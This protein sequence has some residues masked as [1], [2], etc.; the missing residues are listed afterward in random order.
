MSRLRRAARSTAVVQIFSLIGA[1]L[2]LVTVPLYLKW[3]GNE[4]YGLMLTA[5][6]CAGYLMFSDAGLSWASMLLISQ[7]HGRDNRQE[8]AR[9]VRNSISLAA[10]SSLLASGVIFVLLFL[11]QRAESVRLF[12]H[13]S[14]E[15]A[16]LVLAVGFQVV[17]SLMLSPVFNIFIGL[18]E[19]H[20]AAIYQGLGRIIGVGASLLA[21]ALGASLGIIM[22]SA[23][24]CVLAAGAACAVH[25][26]KRHRWA[27]RWG[28]FWEREQIRSQYRAGAKSF[29]LQIG[30]VLVGSAPV[31][32]ISSQ[33]GA[34]FVPGFTVPLTLLNTPLAIVMSFNATLQ[35]GYGEAIG[36]QDFPWIRSTVQSILRNMLLFQGLLVAGFLVLAPAFIKLWTHGR[37]EV[38]LPVLMSVLLVGLTG[39]ILSVF[40]FALSGMNR[41]KAAGLSEVINGLLCLGLG[42]LVV[43][44]AGYEWIGLGIFAAAAATSVWILPGQLRK[45]LDMK[46]LWPRASFFFCLIMASGSAGLLGYLCERS[47]ILSSWVSIIISG[48]VI[49]VCYFGL[50]RF[51]LPEDFRRL[52]ALLAKRRHDLSVARPSADQLPL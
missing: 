46:Q 7:A 6:A 31:I 3:L 23:T 26:W 44:F 41:H 22:V 36:R 29:A 24:C 5:F 34:R 15:T 39:S 25:A 40:Q 52:R 47:G 32:S 35:P 10:I 9:I 14:P 17:V 43:H 28:S 12:P 37:I 20:L 49:A 11:G 1:A 8:I 50:L 42:A 13:F 2:S 27:F 51:V 18:Q 48:A 21:A 4:R 45:H 16:G 33:A 19:A 38:A 30:R